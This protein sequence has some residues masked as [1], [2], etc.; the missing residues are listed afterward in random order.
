MSSRI[1]EDYPPITPSNNVDLNVQ[2]GNQSLLLGVGIL[3]LDLLV[4][5]AVGGIS[6]S[7]SQQWRQISRAGGGPYLRSFSMRSTWVMTMRRQQ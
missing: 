5:A 6:G 3:H 2:T 4:V 7:Q 1:R